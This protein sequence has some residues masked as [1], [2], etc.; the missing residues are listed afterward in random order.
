MKSL[1]ISLL[2][3]AAFS[4]HAQERQPI[5]AFPEPGMDDPAA[6][7]GYTTRFFRDTDGNVLQISINRETGRV[8]HLWADA[9]NESISFTVR[10]SDGSLTN[11]AWSSTGA[12]GST[13]ENV[14]MLEH[15]LSVDAA[16]IEIGHFVLC[17]M[18]K[19]RDFQYFRKHLEPFSAPPFIDQ[20]L[21]AL[22][23]NLQKLPADERKRQLDLLN[24]GDIQTLRDRLQPTIALTRRGSRWVA[25]IKQPTFDGRNH[26]T[27]EL[28][29]DMMH[30][31]ARAT[32]QSIIASARSGTSIQLRVRIGSDSPALTPLNRLEIFN[33]EFFQ[34]YSTVKASRDS[35]YP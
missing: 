19:E 28:S 34:Y 16:A 14:R 4:L 21:T 27:L 8:V 2:L 18:R 20:E 33:E 30:S 15:T 7:R 22:I 35:A 10:K 32:E 5:L 24:S 9:A 1:F 25:S 31:V 11:L 3:L 23:E 13:E 26:L 29:G 12:A 17:S 6:Y